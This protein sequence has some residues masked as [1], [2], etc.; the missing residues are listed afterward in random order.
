MTGGMQRLFAVYLFFLLAGVLFAQSTS[1]P[2]DIEWLTPLRS[3]ETLA[4]AGLTS[5][6]QQQILKQLEVTSFDAPDSWPAELRVRRVSLGGVAG[7]VVRATQLLCGG[8]GNCQAWVFRRE[9]DG[10]LNMFEGEAPVVSS[11]GFMR[12]T[13]VVQDLVVTANLSAER[14]HWTR[15]RFDG[16]VYRRTECYQVGGGVQSRRAERVECP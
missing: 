12:Q 4:R 3:T 5:A 8:T 9:Q 6:E 7:L 2:A 11:V 10:W 1:L 13:G 16:K 14:E 15:Y